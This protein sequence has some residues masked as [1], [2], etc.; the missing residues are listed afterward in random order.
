MN[1][2]PQNHEI[3]MH[4]I[5]Q[6]DDHNDGAE[7][8]SMI[9]EPAISDAFSLMD[10]LSLK[11]KNLRCHLTIIKWVGVVI[12]ATAFTVPGVILLVQQDSSHQ[13][14]DEGIQP[15]LNKTACVYVKQFYL[16]D[17]IYATV[18]NQNGYVFVDI[19]QFINGT[20]TIIGVD[21]NLRQWLTLKQHT[22][23]IDVAIAEARTYWRELKLYEGKS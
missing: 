17:Q 3:E 1:S 10:E 9:A 4:N 12:L 6:V 7:I 14:F 23:T 22:R 15:E 21:L 13:S 8:S 18:C 5:P 2:V 20:A 19:R 16:Q 11:H